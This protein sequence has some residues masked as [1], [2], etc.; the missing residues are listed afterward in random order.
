MR[1]S[2]LTREATR[3]SW[4]GVVESV[5]VGD[6]MVGPLVLV[7]TTPAMPEDA[8]LAREQGALVVAK[9]ISIEDFRQAVERLCRSG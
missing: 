5:A 6:A 2:R 3:G 9:P 8:L 1:A 7:P 4:H